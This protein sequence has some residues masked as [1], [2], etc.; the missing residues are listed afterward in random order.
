MILPVKKVRQAAQLPR[1]GTAGAAGLDLHACLKD[2]RLL[3]PGNST[4][5]PTGIACAIP[6][7][8]VGL[9]WDRGSTAKRGLHTLAGVV[10]GDYR[11]EIM[12][13]VLNTSKTSQIIA[14][15]ER[16]AQMLVVPCPQVDVVEV[17]QLSETKRGE[18]AFGSTGR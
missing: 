15:G 6:E 4:I 5:V 3:L 9:I 2:T 14:P 8:F 18:G 11:G 7:G 10:D 13:V 16:I 12:V 1:Y 17:D